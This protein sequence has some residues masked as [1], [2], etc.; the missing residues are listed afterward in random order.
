[1]KY[2]I[3]A[4]KLR[5]EYRAVLYNGTECF[6]ARYDMPC[7]GSPMFFELEKPCPTTGKV[8]FLPATRQIFTAGFY[9]VRDKFGLPTRIAQKTPLHQECQ[10]MIDKYNQ[11]CSF[12]EKPK[13]K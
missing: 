2:D 10:R 6:T 11:L 12:N 5:D 13:R 8:I 4:D 3:F 7:C 9:L 1:M